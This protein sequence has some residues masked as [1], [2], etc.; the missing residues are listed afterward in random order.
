VVPYLLRR[1]VGQRGGGMA[2]RR[3]TDEASTRA[4]AV[5]EERGEVGGWGN[6]ASNERER[7]GVEGGG[8]SRGG[9]SGGSGSDEAFVR[10]MRAPQLTFFPPS[11]AV[12]IPR[13]NRHYGVF[14]CSF[15]SLT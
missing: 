15:I 12:L 14:F 10:R 7:G 3:P 1:D 4:R 13:L 8:P 9:A 5:A 11:S 2:E 6:R